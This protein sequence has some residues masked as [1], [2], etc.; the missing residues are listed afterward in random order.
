MGILVRW[1]LGAVSSL[2]DGTVSLLGGVMPR[3]VPTTTLRTLAYLLWGF[4]VFVVFQKVVS[5]EHRSPRH[6]PRA[7]RYTMWWMP[8]RAPGS[9]MLWMTD[10]VVSTGSL[11]GG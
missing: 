9:T 1:V 11:C 4:F 8:W 5:N 6:L 7:Q 2:S 3:A 10:N